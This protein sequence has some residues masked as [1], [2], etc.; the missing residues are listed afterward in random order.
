V[1]GTVGLGAF[2]ASPSASPKNTRPGAGWQRAEPG[3]PHLLSNLAASA[4]L[5]T[6]VAVTA[7]RTPSLEDMLRLLNALTGAFADV[8]PGRSGLLRVWAHLPD[9]NRDPDVDALRVLLMADLLARTGE[10][11]GLQV[12]TAV[13]FP[14]EPPAQRSFAERVAGSLGIHPPAMR[15][16]SAEAAAL[17]G[18]QAHVRIIGPDGSLDNDEQGALVVR[19]GA[20]SVTRPAQ[21]LAS[22][23]MFG[24]DD[25]LAVRF[26]LMSVPHHQHADLD[27]TVLARAGQRASSW[28]LRVAEWAES[29]SRPIPEGV[30]STVQS[31]FSYLDT[32]QVLAVLDEMADNP[33]LSPGTRF[34]TFAFADRI[35]ALGLAREVGRPRQ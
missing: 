32:A 11:G 23:A 1:T 34:E 27:N 19:V 2:A 18:G 29:P 28:R 4:R 30:R 7:S 22:D 21:P 24:G 20:V 8:R 10:L 13:V 25:A 9:Q 17:F 5:V 15:V 14:S 3:L 35:L 6:A 31:A 26:A 33:S 12:L 16:G